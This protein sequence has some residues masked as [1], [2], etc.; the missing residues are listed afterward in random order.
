MFA[1]I[2]KGSSIPCKYK[3]L[4]MRVTIGLV[5]DGIGIIAA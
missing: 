5:V 4:T 3:D 1:H 2:C